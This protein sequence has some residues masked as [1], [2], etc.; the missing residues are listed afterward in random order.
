MGK[1][2][3]PC[4]TPVFIDGSILEVI[5]LDIFEWSDCCYLSP[6]MKELYNPI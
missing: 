2:S 4:G 1:K 5:A 6:F 3:D